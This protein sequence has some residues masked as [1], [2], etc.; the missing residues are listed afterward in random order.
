MSN[1]NLKIQLIEN[2]CLFELAWGEGQQLNATLTY[3]QSI[4]ISYHEWQQY[5][6]KFYKNSFRGKV[7]DIGTIAAPPIDWR[8]KLVEAETKF[9]YEFRHWLRS[10][11]LYQIRSTI[12]NYQLPIIN[13]QLPIT[14]T[15][16]FYHLQLLRIRTF[17]LGS[18][19][20]WE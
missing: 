5:Y 8:A 10:A 1:F 17:T 15:K 7:A 2:S 6:L 9:L 11:E 12:T 14:Q 13:Y 19:E 20:Y 18:L 3:P 16:C 4:A